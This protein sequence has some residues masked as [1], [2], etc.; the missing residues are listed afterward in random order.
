[1]RYTPKITSIF[2]LCASLYAPLTGHTS[3]ESVSK[4]I[5]A[6]TDIFADTQ[7]TLSQQINTLRD[8]LD[9]MNACASSGKAYAPHHAGADNNKCIAILSESDIVE[10]VR[11]HCGFVVDNPGSVS[12]HNVELL[13]KDTYDF[14]DSNNATT[15]LKWR[16]E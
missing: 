6:L 16:C 10:Y 7:G 3:A 1:M 4:Q 2:A 8:M 15:T 9:N 5:S 12:L 11:E 14:Y 13:G